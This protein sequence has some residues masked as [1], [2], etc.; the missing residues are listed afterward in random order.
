[1]HHH[2]GSVSNWHCQIVN[3]WWRLNVIWKNCVIDIL[4][5]LWFHLAE[6]WKLFINIIFFKNTFLEFSS[7]FELSFRPSVRSAGTMNVIRPGQ[8]PGFDIPI[9]EMLD[10]GWS[11]LMRSPGKN[12]RVKNVK[13]EHMRRIWAQ[14]IANFLTTN[15]PRAIPAWYGIFESIGFASF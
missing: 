14:F 15:P 1:M 7:S 12:G 8:W 13:I 2:S 6:Y 4:I 11:Y 5:F 3:S 10:R 9:I